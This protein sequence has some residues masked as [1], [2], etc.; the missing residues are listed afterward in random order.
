M[1]YAPLSAK[2]NRSGDL[3]TKANDP[4]ATGS[5][6]N[7]SREDTE[8]AIQQRE[9]D[10]QEDEKKDEGMKGEKRQK[11]EKG[12]DDEEEEEEDDEDTKE[13]EVDVGQADDLDED[14]EMPSAVKVKPATT[15]FSAMPRPVSTPDPKA[16]KK[17]T[18]APS[19]IA[20]IYK[21][22]ALPTLF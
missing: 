7:V 22:V 2:R 4:K 19:L 10:E 13:V 6:S 20:S 12:E 11:Q 14:L 1:R 18:T 17:G 8:E 16:G 9:E 5:T 3:G 21:T 15:R